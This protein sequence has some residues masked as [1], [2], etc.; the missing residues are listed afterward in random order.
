MTKELFL[1][2]G[3]PGSGKSTLA[4][5]L[6]GSLV[7]ADKFFMEYGEYK[8]DASKLKEAHAWCRNQVK[9]WMETNDRGFDVPRIVVSNT[10]TQEWEMKPY[11][12]LAK[13]YGYIVFSLIVENRH[14]GQNVHNVP[15][16]VIDRMRTRFEIS[17]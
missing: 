14:G 8:F 13:E 6:G 9:E 5:Q 11:Y 4:N 15:E 16:E 1:L 17:L 3:L 12:D 10:F 7:E 2:R